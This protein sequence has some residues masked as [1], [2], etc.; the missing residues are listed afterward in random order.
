MDADLHLRRKCAFADLAI[1]GRAGEPGAGEDGLDPDNSVSAGHG[2]GVPFYGGQ[3]LPQG[4]ASVGGILCARAFP[5]T[6]GASERQAAK[7]GKRRDTAT[8]G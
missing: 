1:E 5:A 4:Q 7:T 6:L 3:W 8:D 2:D